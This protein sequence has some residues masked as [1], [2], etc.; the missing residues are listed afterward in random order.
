MRMHATPEACLARCGAK[1][2]ALAP[3]GSYLRLT[4]SVAL[5]VT[6]A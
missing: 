2:E 5:F 3:G 1:V 6:P 4:V